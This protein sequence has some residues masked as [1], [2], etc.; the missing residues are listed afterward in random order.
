MHGAG[1]R[2]FVSSYLAQRS[3]GNLGQ[4]NT[5]PETEPGAAD[6]GVTHPALSGENDLVD[7]KGHKAE[8]TDHRL[9][10]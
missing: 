3:L 4:L 7:M 1:Q 10:S 8:N 9:Y 2:P 5:I 6:S